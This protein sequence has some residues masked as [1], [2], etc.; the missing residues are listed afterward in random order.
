MV[1]RQTYSGAEV[2][3]HPKLE[4]TTIGHSE[5]INTESIQGGA[6]KIPSGM[7]A[8]KVSFWIKALLLLL[9]FCPVSSFLHVMV[10]LWLQ[11]RFPKEQFLLEFPE[12]DVHP[13]SPVQSQLW[14]PLRG[15]HTGADAEWRGKKYYFAAT[16]APSKQRPCEMTADISNR[17]S[18]GLIYRF[19]RKI[20]T[21]H[22][23]SN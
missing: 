10:S 17:H 5:W 16:G 6:G 15:F 2:L 4:L 1:E 7:M 8:M 13:F 20:N 11:L 14:K 23:H 22:A 21:V 3:V 9:L 19:G 12:D 18:T